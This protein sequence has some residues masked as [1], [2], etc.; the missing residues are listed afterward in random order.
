M[1][2]WYDFNFKIIMQVANKKREQEKKPSL[3]K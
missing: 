3:N 2:L 1:H